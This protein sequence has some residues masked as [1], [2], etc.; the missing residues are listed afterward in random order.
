GSVFRLG[1]FAPALGIWIWGTMRYGSRHRMPERSTNH[2]QS[3]PLGLRHG[4]ILL[5][6]TVTFI[7]LIFGILRLGWHFEQM[8]A[9]FFLMGIA[10]GLIGQLRLAGTAE[11]FVE[12]FR[13]MAYAALLIGFARAIYIVLDEG[14]IVDTIVHALFAPIALLPVHLSALGMM[15]VQSILHFPVPSVS[16]Q[17]VLTL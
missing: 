14:R 12:G 5:V 17:A 3:G 13:S 11:A 16:G 8:S 15:F 7:V 10:A 1:F 4:L 2:E 9:L 6:L